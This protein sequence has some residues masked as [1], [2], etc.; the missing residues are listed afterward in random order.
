MDVAAYNRTLFRLGGAPPEKQLEEPLTQSQDIPG[1]VSRK[2]VARRARH[3]YPQ[4]G[5][6][7]ETDVGQSVG[8]DAEGTNSQALSLAIIPPASEQ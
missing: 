7:D 1:Y 8:N 5:N 4:E 6:S 2:R 3:K